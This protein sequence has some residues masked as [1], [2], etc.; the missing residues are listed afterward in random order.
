M[1][2]LAS[3]D[4]SRHSPPLAIL[5]RSARSASADG[6]LRGRSESSKTGAAPGAPPSCIR[7]TDAHRLLRRWT[8]EDVSPSIILH[9]R[10]MS[11]AG[12]VHAGSLL[13]G[14]SGSAAPSENSGQVVG[15]SNASAPP[16]TLNSPSK[17]LR[18]AGVFIWTPSSW[19]ASWTAATHA[20]DPPT[21]VSARAPAV[22]SLYP[23]IFATAWTGAEEET[24]A[25]MRCGN[26]ERAHAASMPGY[27]PPNVIH[28][29]SAGRLC[30][31][32]M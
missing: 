22:T 13:C 30:S 10:A 31:L 28:F 32:E 7:D 1:A 12:S 17:R 15:G 8:L 18:P 6:A 4:A 9:W 11:H 29:V 3:Y 16:H 5:F 24:A 2:T 19:N 20:A 27:D 26:L 23:C 21:A 14:I 25:W